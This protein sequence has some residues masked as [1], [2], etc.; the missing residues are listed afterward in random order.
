MIKNVSTVTGSTINQEQRV[1]GFGLGNPLLFI[2]KL[3]EIIRCGSNWR[4]DEVVMHSFDADISD[5]FHY[6]LS[7]ARDVVCRYRIGNSHV[8]FAMFEV[9]S[10]NTESFSADAA[11]VGFF[12]RMKSGVDLFNNSQL[13]IH[14]VYYLSISTSSYLDPRL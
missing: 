9:I 5:G 11:N 13:F 12:S 3:E 10:P 6:G 4:Y 14:S 7:I 2:G 1:E 8:D